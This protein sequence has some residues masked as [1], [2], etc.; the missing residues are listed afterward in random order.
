MMAL[1]VICKSKTQTFEQQSQKIYYST[2]QSQWVTPMHHTMIRGL[3]GRK[4]KISAHVSNIY[5]VDLVSLW[6]AMLAEVLNQSWQN[7]FFSMLT[8]TENHHQTF[9]LQDRV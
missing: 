2:S 1:Q 9:V 5:L 8:I 6:V 4:Q 3:T 7:D